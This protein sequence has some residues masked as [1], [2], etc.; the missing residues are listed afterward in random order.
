MGQC[1]LLQIAVQLVLHRGEYRR[2]LIGGCCR[3]A[4]RGRQQRRDVAGLRAALRLDLADV[5]H[6]GSRRHRDPSRFRAALPGEHFRRVAACHD[7]GK[8]RQRRADHVHPAHQFVRPTVNIHPVHLQRHHVERVQAAALPRIGKAARHRPDIIAV[9]LP[10]PLGFLHEH[11]AE[12]RLR[13]G[14][15]GLDHQ[16][17]LP[18]HRVAAAR[19][20]PVPVACG[21]AVQRHAAHQEFLQ[22]AAHHVVHAARLHALVVIHVMPVQVGARITRERRVAVH[23][24]VSRKHPLA[25]HLLEGL[26]AG[27]QAVSLQPVP[28][29]FMEEHA[30]R[31]TGKDRRTRVRVCHRGGFQCL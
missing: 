14:M 23:G 12:F 18:R 29:N 20:A 9:V 27:L 10:L 31:R 24:K 2:V 4:F 16:V 5:N 15:R 13:I 17:R 30:A 8:H 26:P 28:E 1:Q 6:R 7:I 21:E 25:H 3:F 19:R 22:H 11:G